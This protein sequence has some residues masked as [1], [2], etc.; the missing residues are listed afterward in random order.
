MEPGPAA[1]PDT[2]SLRALHAYLLGTLPFDA[3]AALQRRLAFDV[4]GDPA[5]GAVVVCDH[6][7]GVTVGRD[8]SR[9]DVRLGPKALAAREWP[10]HWVGRGGG[11]MLH[12]PG[13]VACYPVLAL[14]RLGLTVGAYLQM[15]QD[16]VAGVLAEFDIAATTDAARPGLVVKGRRVAHV[17]VS[18]RDNV[19]CFGVV[20]NVCPDLHP[21]RDVRCD[22]DP[23][24]MTSML[25]ESPARVRLPGVRQRLVEAVAATVRLRPRFPVPPPPGG[26]TLTGPPC[27]PYPCSVA[28]PRPTAAAAGCP[29]G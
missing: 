1:P 26:C 15:L 4:A 6:P 23:A 28:R 9:L 14:G 12:L 10:L 29:R 2:P 16:T 21:F 22:G 20:L 18:V 7:A 17:G 11:A 5:A 8:G 25:R 19:T 24:P 13:Q 3:A 27:S